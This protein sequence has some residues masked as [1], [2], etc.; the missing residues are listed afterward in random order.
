MINQEQYVVWSLELHI[1]FG[2]IMKEHSLFLEAGFTP[3]NPNFS[4]VADQY[5]EQFE[6]IL[7]NAVILGNGVISP[8]VVNSG[9]IVTEFTLRSEQ[10]TE[11]FTGIDINKKI[12]RLEREL[13]G[14]MNPM[15]TPDLAQQVKMLNTQA[16]PLLEGLID[17]KTQIL[18]N[19]LSCKMFTV[20]Y[21]LLIEHILRE[22]KMYLSH[23][24]SLEN[25]ESIDDN[26]KEIE[27]F[28]DQI[29]LEHALFIRGLLDPTENDLINTSNDFAQDY[30]D[31]LQSARNATDMTLE[32]ITDVTLEQTM[33]YRDF[34][35]AGT[36]GIAECKIRSIILPLLGD[37]VLREANHFI[38]LLQQFS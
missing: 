2:R 27:L 15:I 11:N 19:V 34:K 1:F 7:N 37:H 13:Q 32:G 31:L 16:I 12:T 8:N 17:F 38:R 24:C 36:E 30:A 9:E 35:A 29:M 33:K 22:A 26:I 25:G 23:L 21:P 18:N 3:A 28:W 14:S 20:N 10:M 6:I 5:K 4:K